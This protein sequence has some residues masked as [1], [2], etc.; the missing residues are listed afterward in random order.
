MTSKANKINPF[1]NNEFLYQYC[2]FANVI[3]NDNKTINTEL[4]YPKR[5]N[6]KIYNFDEEVISFLD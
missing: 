1:K 3:I 6:K 4:Y 5:E 2:K